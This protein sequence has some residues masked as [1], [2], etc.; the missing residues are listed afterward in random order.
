MNAALSLLNDYAGAIAAA[1]C[2]LGVLLLIWL[3]CLSRRVR[4]VTPDT[5]RLVRELNGLDARGMFEAHLAHM[6]EALGKAGDVER[7][8]TELGRRQ[9]YSLQRVGLIRFNSDRKLGGDLSFALALL[10]DE[11]DGVILTSI[12]NLEECRTYAKPVKAGVCT[13]ATSEEEQRAL[14]SALNS[15]QAAGTPG[16]R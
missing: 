16:N 8:A 1:A 11:N 6:Q 13:V 4:A 5:R 12:Y 3:A 9:T 15:Q 7:L 2:V 10:N 14:S